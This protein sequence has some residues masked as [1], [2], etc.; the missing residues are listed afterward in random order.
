MAKIKK[1]ADFETERKK[2]RKKLRIELKK[3]A[4]I[5]PTAPWRL[6]S[7]SCAR[8]SCSCQRASCQ[9]ECYKDKNMSTAKKKKKKDE[10]KKERRVWK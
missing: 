1:L 4:Y 3:K 2:Y 10:R 9:L 8:K 6:W 5:S 7:Q